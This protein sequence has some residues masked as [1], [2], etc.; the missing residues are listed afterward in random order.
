A[1]DVPGHCVVEV[2]PTQ[3]KSEI[4]VWGGSGP[5]ALLMRRI[6]EQFDPRGTLNPGRFVDGI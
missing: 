6:K 2:C 5:Q 4:D 1:A 3:L